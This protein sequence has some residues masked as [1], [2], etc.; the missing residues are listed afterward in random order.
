MGKQTLQ[1]VNNWKE[2]RS[3]FDDEAR[4]I[5]KSLDLRTRISFMSG[6]LTRDEIRN[7]ILH[8]RQKHYNE[9]PYW[10]GGHLE[11][12]VMPVLFVDGS[13]GVV[14]GNGKYTGFPVESLRAATF[15]PDLE[16][17]VGEAIAKEVITAGGNLFGGV[18][19]NL[20]YHPGGGRSQESYGEDTYLIGCMG[21][22]MVK[23]IQ[24]L[25]VI[26]SIKHFAFNSMENNRLVINITSDKRT[27]QEVFLP[28]FKKCIEAGAGCVMTAYNSYNGKP[29]GHNKH[30]ITEVLRDDW[31]YDGFVMC[32]FTWGISDTLEAINAGMDLEM[33]HTLYY[34]DALYDAVMDGRVSEDYINEAAVRIVRTILAHEDNVFLS[35]EMLKHQKENNFKKHIQLALEVARKGI[36][37]L[38]NSNNTLPLHCGGHGHKIVILG[39]LAISD[40]LGDHGSSCTYPP[41]V[42]HVVDGI[43]NNVSGAEIIYYSGD[44]LTHC[45][46]IVKDASAVIIIAGNDYKSEGEHVKADESVNSSFTYGGDRVNGIALSKEHLDIIDAVSDI[47]DDAIIVLTGGSAFTVEEFVDKVGA[48]IMQ[49]YP[50]MEGGN[51][52]GE[53]LFGKVNPSGHIPFTIPCHEEDLAD[54]KWDATE[55]HYE[56]FHGYTRLEKLHKPIRY[57]FGHGL[58][59]TTFEYSDLKATIEEDKLVATFKVRNSGNYDGDCVPMMFIKTPGI[60]VE[61]EERLLKGFKRISLQKGEEKEVTL[62]TKLAELNYYD[63]SSNSWKFESGKYLIMVDSLS[64]E[65][66]C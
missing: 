59:Y 58:S 1:I 44:N 40:N 66:T 30:L 62:E 54:V 64:A 13:R 18:C 17:R 12:H 56:F 7:D 5:I 20:L 46:R 8:K 26:A 49:F 22:S 38:K 48:I 60:A 36:T 65:I 15:D 35:R 23:G 41:Y 9:T 32:D 33:P 6:K 24:S 45:R 11:K 61:R 51:A 37:L 2:Y 39:S 27:E 57:P 3:K 52:L 19:L 28:H 53:I 55:Q 29:C 43:R 21:S 42:T 31:G 16:Y 47:R 50:G 25:G 14:C 10:A 34:G 63:E 4:E